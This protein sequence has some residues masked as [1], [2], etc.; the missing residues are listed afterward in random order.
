MER[1]AA[2]SA[3]NTFL[4]PVLNL[5]ISRLIEGNVHKQ[6][7]KQVTGP[8]QKNVWGWVLQTSSARATLLERCYIENRKRLIKQLRCS[9]PV[10][11]PVG[12]AFAFYH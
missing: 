11:N 3:S 8:S 6:V 9:I 5:Q 10:Y 12:S 4:E 1:A 7:L 2:L